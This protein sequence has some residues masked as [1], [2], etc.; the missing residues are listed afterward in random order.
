MVGACMA[1]GERSFM[2]GGHRSHGH[3]IAKGAN[4]QPLMAELMAR[5]TGVCKGKGGS[6]HLAAR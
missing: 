5:T 4:I 2:T 1:A 6:L 3:H